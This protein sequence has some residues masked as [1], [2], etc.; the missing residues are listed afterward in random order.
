[1]M[2]D[3]TKPPPGAPP[4]PPLQASEGEYRTLF[5]T[6]DEGFVL[7]EAI[8]M[9][10]G[11]IDMRYDTV[12]PAWEEILGVRAKDV[13]GRTAREVF[14]KTEEAWFELVARV[15]FGG[16]SITVEKFFATIGKWLECVFSPLGESGRG[17]LAILF[18]DI[19]ERKRREANLALLAEV[20]RDLVGLASI[21]ETMTA[22]G[23]KIGR[24]FGVRQCVFAEHMDEYK[25]SITS[26]GWHAEGARDLKGGYRT[27]DFFTDEMVAA[28]LAGE[29]FVVADTQTDPRVSAQSYRALGVHAFI[30]VPLLRNGE[31]GFHISIIDDRARVWRDD[32]KELIREIASRIWV[33]LESARAEQRLRESEARL[34]ALLAALPVGVALVGL[35]GRAIFANQEWQRHLPG[36][37]IPSQDRSDPPRWRA[38]HA[39]GRPVEL[40]DFPGARALRGETVVPGIEMLHTRADGSE[41][42]MQVA[43]VPVKDGEGR[44]TGQ[45]GVIADIDASKRTK[46]QLRE[47]DRRKSEFLAMLG[48]ELRNPL[49]AVEGGIKLLQS[50]RSRPESRAAALPIVAQ[51][52]AHMKRLIDDLL[53]FARLERGKLQV[54]LTDIDLDTTIRQSLHMVEALAQAKEARI[55]YQP[56][57]APLRLHADADRLVQVFGNLLTNALKFSA[58]KCVVEIWI[59]RA[60]TTVSIHVRDEG[61]GIAAE[62]IATIFEP[63]VQSNFSLGLPEGGLGL[64]LSVSQELVALHGGRITATSAGPGQGSTFVVM[65]PVVAET[66]S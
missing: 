23:A 29:M 39:D 20:S 22:L 66:I 46:D 45:V 55:D 38:W 6:I 58:A 14:P 44:V 52:I 19:T 27:R 62:D 54:K 56:P 43:A 9:A 7:G 16:E 1:M 61:R 60:P 15:G 63:F 25:T 26:Y 59:E 13:R 3:P 11:A 32:E 10:S 41:R 53:D 24:H 48:H 34:A 33:R 42:W 47:A 64:G 21:D 57:V 4:A 36:G 31:W 17:K 18:K 49:A 2:P 65:L 50:P 8:R 40:Q 12:N 5:N 35:D 28:V 30:L 51:Q 37:V